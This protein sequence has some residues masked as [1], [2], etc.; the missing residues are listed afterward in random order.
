MTVVATKVWSD[1]PHMLIGP[2]RGGLACVQSDTDQQTIEFRRVTC[3]AAGT[4]KLGCADSA[5][6]T[7]SFTAVVVGQVIDGV[8]NMVYDTGTSLANADIILQI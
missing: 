5:G 4:L 7:L 1:N 6:S 3:C 8:F 2:S